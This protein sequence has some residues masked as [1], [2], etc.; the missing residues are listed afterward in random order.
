MKWF[1]R[2]KQQS[3]LE[4]SPRRRRWAAMNE[5]LVRGS[6]T[7]QGD[8]ISRA[9]SLDLGH[10]AE[11]GKG[12]SAPDKIHHASYASHVGTAWG[13]GYGFRLY[14]TPWNQFN[15]VHQIIV[16]LMCGHAKLGCI[17]FSPTVFFEDCQ[18]CISFQFLECEL[19]WFYSKKYSRTFEGG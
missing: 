9:V 14:W 15:E 11:C 5:A 12:G 18:G 7:A 4:G 19:N 13:G 17:F 3:F 16:V 2:D 8:W 10:A 6:H 1:V